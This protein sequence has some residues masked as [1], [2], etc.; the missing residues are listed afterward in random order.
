M[1]EKLRTTKKTIFLTL[2]I[3]YQ[4]FLVENTILANLK[5]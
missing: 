4:G 2:L 3:I 1:W 5:E